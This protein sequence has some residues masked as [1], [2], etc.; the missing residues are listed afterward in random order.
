M[1]TPNDNFLSY[2][3]DHK[4][5]TAEPK[6][7]IFKRPKNKNELSN[8]AMLAAICSIFL[9]V[10][11]FPS[12]MG[13]TLGV[14]ALIIAAKRKLPKKIP[15]IA[16]IISTV[17]MVLSTAGLLFIISEMTPESSPYI[18]PAYTYSSADGLA[19][20]YNPVSNIPCD[21]AGQ[22]TF[23]VTIFQ[24]EPERCSKGGVFNPQLED[25]R[26]SVQAE[27]QPSEFPALK[28]GEDSTLT[29]VVK[30]EPNSRLV[31]SPAAR[32]ISCNR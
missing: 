20:R 29:I 5:A 26:T 24:I 16:I 23:E 21:S 12:V 22:C 8:A 13:I 10:L 1:N 31:E 2:V 4:I 32:P 15:I 6:K 19:Y 11:I 7:S 30:S 28:A 3:S 14:G 9:G 17:T 18:P 27:G 25:V